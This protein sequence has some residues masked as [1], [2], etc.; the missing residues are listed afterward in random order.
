MPDTRLHR[1]TMFEVPKKED[2]K[3]VIEA[4]RVLQKSAVK[5]APSL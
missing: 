2:R 1:V 3:K 5:V 4:Y